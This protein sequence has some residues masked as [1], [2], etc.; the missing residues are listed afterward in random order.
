M[1]DDVAL[2]ELAAMATIVSRAQLAARAGTQFGGKRDLYSTLGYSRVLTFADHYARYRRQ[3]IA[4]RIVTAKPA[5]TWRHKPVVF[6]DKNPDTDTAFEAVMQACAE[7]PR[8]GQHGTWIQPEMIDAYTALGATAS[9]T[10]ERW[11]LRVH[12]RNLTDTEYATRGFGSAS[13]IPARP[14]EVRARLHVG[15][16]KR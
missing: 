10:K 16:G 6:E 5:A 7:V 8:Q 13:A 12:F 4:R 14:F 3:H 11:G 9:F 2:N 15:F 1:T